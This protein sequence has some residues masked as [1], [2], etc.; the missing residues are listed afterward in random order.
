MKTVLP[1][2]L[3]L[4]V[5]VLPS[6]ASAQRG[7][8]V[9]IEDRI[10]QLQQ[11][12]SQSD[13]PDRAA[14]VPQPAAPAADGEDAGGLRVPARPAREGRQ[15]ARGRAAAAT[16]AASPSAAAAPAA[17]C[18]EQRRPGLSRCLQAPAG[19]RLCRSRAR[20]PAPSSSA[21]RSMSLA[22]NAE[23]WLGETYYA[24][25]DYQNAMTAFAE[26]Y[27][28]YKT[29][30][31]GTGQ[32]AEARHYAGGARPQAGCLRGV[33]P[34]QPRLSA[35]D[36]PAKAS[37]RAGAAEKPVRVT[38]KALTGQ[39]V[40]A[41]EFARLMADIR[42]LRSQADPCR[43]R[44]RRARFDGAGPPGAGLGWERDGTGPGAD[45]RS[46]AARRIPRAKPRKRSMRLARHGM[47]A[48]ILRWIGKQARQRAAGGRAGLRVTGFCSR[49]AGAH[50]IL[51]L[52]VAHHADDQAETIA[53]RAATAGA[54]PMGW[55]AWRPLSSIAHARLL[56]PLL[57]RAPGHGSRRRC[58][59]VAV[60]LDRRSVERRSAASSGLRLRAAGVSAP[61][62]PSGREL[63]AARETRP[64]RGL[65]RDPGIRAAEAV[66]ID[67]GRFAGLDA[68]LRR[69]PAQPGRPGAWEAATIRRGASGWNV[70]WPRLCAPAGPGKSGAN[71]G[72]ARISRYRGVPLMLRRR[73][74]QP[75]AALDCAA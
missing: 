72:G 70:P 54:G 75:P 7:D 46:W 37:C 29:E 22:G 8:A 68:G 39:P 17:G 34:L 2:L 30:P 61:A 6:A 47:A 20:L 42:G 21:I 65:G 67:Q 38:T 45:R 1:R 3:V 12:L 31:E 74:G 40:V 56:R 19:R 26:G 50:G 55:P 49:P 4:A 57:G 16:G 44:F 11:S 27:K 71:R 5:F 51:H 63:R 24:R 52:L 35:C 13:R 10:N 73:P 36:R 18:R 32:S 25:R 23:Y 28:V 58:W 43:C 33:R 53:M 59:R 64:G 69:G 14:A 9:Y 62:T 48:E 66:A 41:F 60:A 15:A